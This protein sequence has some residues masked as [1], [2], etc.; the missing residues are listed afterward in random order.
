MG[1]SCPCRWVLLAWVCMAWV[2]GRGNHFLWITVG[3]GVVAQDL[4]MRIQALH[5]V[6]SIRLVARPRALQAYWT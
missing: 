2:W 3:C 1:G 6:I 5:A 4:G